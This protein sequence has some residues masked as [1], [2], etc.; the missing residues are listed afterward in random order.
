MWVLD[1][2]SVSVLFSICCSVRC[3]GFSFS[4]L[5]LMCDRLSV[6][7]IIFSRC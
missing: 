6:L 4:V 2:I 3:V 7:L 1:F 5:D